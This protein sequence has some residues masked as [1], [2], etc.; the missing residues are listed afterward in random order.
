[1]ANLQDY[2]QDGENV[3]QNMLGMLLFQSMNNG[4]QFDLFCKKIG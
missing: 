4:Y 1:M 2:F 3:D